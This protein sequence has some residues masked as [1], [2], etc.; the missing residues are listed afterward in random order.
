MMRI[1]HIRKWLYKIAMMKIY[2]ELFCLLIGFSIARYL[3]KKK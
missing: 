1:E 3:N 2:V